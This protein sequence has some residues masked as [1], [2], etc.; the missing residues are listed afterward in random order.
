MARF[1]HGKEHVTSQIT[2][3]IHYKLHWS[4][5]PDHNMFYWCSDIQLKEIVKSINERED[6]ADRFILADLQ[7]GELFIKSDRLEYVQKK[8]KEYSNTLQFEPKKES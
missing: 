3:S 8:V 7:G 6:P 2:F 1:W 4:P 5:F